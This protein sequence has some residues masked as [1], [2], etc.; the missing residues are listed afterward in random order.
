[1]NSSSCSTGVSST[2]GSSLST[3]FPSRSGVVSFRTISVQPECNV[4]QRPVASSSRRPHR[5]AD[6]QQCAG[7]DSR[8][9]KSTVAE[10]SEIRRITGENDCSDYNDRDG[11]KC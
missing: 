4:S 5:E 10:P 1:M 8:S 3:I 2:S 7:D 9:G 11:Q 6:Q